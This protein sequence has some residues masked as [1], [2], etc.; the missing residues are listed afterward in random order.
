[1]TKIEEQVLEYIA[2]NNKFVD[3]VDIHR[4]FNLPLEKACEIVGSLKRQKLVRRVNSEDS[5]LFLMVGE[6]LARTIC[7]KLLL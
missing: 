6:E 4:K 1:M 2:R 3:V 5:N 7:A